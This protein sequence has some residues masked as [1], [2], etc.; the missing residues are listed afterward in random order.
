M[1]ARSDLPA[2]T[3]LVSLIAVLA[4]LANAAHGLGAF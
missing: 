4:S 2:I 3:L 1:I